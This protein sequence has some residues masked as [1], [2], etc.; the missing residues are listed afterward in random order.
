M[1]K[2][3]IYGLLAGI[4]VIFIIIALPKFVSKLIVT[5]LAVGAMHEYIKTIETMGYKPLKAVSYLSCSALLF[6]GNFN[7]LSIYK[8]TG[9]L[10]GLFVMGSL[11]YACFMR[12][13]KTSITDIA[14]TFFGILYVTFLLSFL[15]KVLYMDVNG[16]DVG[17]FIIWFVLFGACLT[18][19]FAYFI[20][21][22]F[23]KHKL[24]P[25]I[26]PKKSVEG[27]IG[28]IV[29]CILS[30]LVYSFVLNKYCGFSIEYLSMVFI[31]I[32][33]SVFS[34]FGDLVASSIKRNA[35]I[36]DFGNFLPGHGGILDRIDSI[37]F[38]APVTY[39]IFSLLI[40]YIY[41][42]G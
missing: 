39:Y 28:G 13:E 23:G 3:I 36:K 30:F 14:F 42:V 21:S 38:V 34:Q 27:A 33:I 37:L 20:G 16:A 25:H 32:A 31:A 7:L 10:A 18:D 19:A 11:I 9:I 8:W 22:K 29:G 15:L 17:K 41:I 24:C 1:L 40:E 6:V 35:N 5:A 4:A 2:R 26:S 12:K